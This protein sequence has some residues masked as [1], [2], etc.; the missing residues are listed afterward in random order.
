MSLRAKGTPCKG[1]RGPPA[2]ISASASLAWRRARSNV[3]VM[4]ARVW[5]SYCSTRWISASTSSTGESFR[6]AIRLPSSAIERS[7]RSLPMESSP[8]A[9]TVSLSLR[10]D[11]APAAVHGQGHAAPKT[12]KCSPHAEPP[13]FFKAWPAAGRPPGSSSAERE[14]EEGV[15][16]VIEEMHAARV[17]EG[18]RVVLEA[19]GETTVGRRGSR[20]A[21]ARMLRHEVVSLLASRD[22][23]ARGGETLHALTEYPHHEE[24]VVADVPPEGQL[25]LGLEIRGVLTPRRLRLEEHIHDRLEPGHRASGRVELIG[26]REPGEQIGEV[27]GHGIA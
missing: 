7:C 8:P 14:A 12:M 16:G 21:S 13:T 15:L 26:A 22:V 25:L 5:P 11:P 17:V 20:R 9:W 24:G 27:A 2:A 23:V 1:P 4:K 10:A 18:A 6:A 19:L 3:R